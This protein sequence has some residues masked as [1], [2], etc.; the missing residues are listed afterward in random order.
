MVIRPFNSENTKTIG[1]FPAIFQIAQVGG[2]TLPKHL[3][4][5]AVPMLLLCDAKKDYLNGSEIAREITRSIRY[6]I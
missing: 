3:H 1:V 4:A 6:W 5:I 2:H